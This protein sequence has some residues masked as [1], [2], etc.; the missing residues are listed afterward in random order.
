MC[1]KGGKRKKRAKY[2][3]PRKNGNSLCN[4]NLQM[5]AAYLAKHTAPTLTEIK[6]NQASA[7]D[8]IGQKS[9]ISLV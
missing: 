7:V 4:I 8:S 2:Q 3:N 9:K 6:Q 1:K 5:L